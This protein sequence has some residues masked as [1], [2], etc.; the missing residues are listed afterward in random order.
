[1]PVLRVLSSSEDEYVRASL[2][3]EGLPDHDGQR[4][5]RA[6]R[7]LRVRYRGYLA[8]EIAAL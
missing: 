3:V 5:V 8:G 4:R 7:A 6:D 1:M 2:N